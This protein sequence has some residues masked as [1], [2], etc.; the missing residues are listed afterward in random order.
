MFNCSSTIC[1]LSFLHWVVF[2]LSWKISWAHL[3]PSI[4]EFSI[5]FHWSI[6]LSLQSWLLWPYNVWKAG[7]LIFPMLFFFFKIVLAILVPLSFLVPQMVKNLLAMKETQVRSL[8][9]E[10][11]LEKGMATHSSILAWRI[12]WTE[13]PG[14]LQSMESQRGR[15][16]WVTDTHTVPL[17]FNLNLEW[18]C[19]Y[20]PKTSCRDFGRN[21]IKLVSIGVKGYWFFQS[22]NTVCFSICDYF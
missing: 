12:P 18:S 9:R 14:R 3:F 1:W 5:R 7:K 13:G 15:H 21:Y 11:P 6:C 16:S 20:L 2:A 17:P 8:S 19:L 10:D 22:M 4:S